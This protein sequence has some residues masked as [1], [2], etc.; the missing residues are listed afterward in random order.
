MERYYPYKKAKL[1]VVGISVVLLLFSFT[2]PAFYIA[3]E[4]HEWSGV[5]AFFFGLFGPLLCTSGVS[6]LANPALVFAWVKLR[7]TPKVSVVASFVALPIAGFFATCHTVM[8]NEAGGMAG[9]TGLEPG[10]YLWI[11]S[12][13]AWFVGSVVIYVLEQ[14]QLGKLQKVKE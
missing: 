4:D 9:I 14:R 5:G 2:Q 13:S 3:R 6:W 7:K 11:A 10:Y 12:I 8:V 1:V